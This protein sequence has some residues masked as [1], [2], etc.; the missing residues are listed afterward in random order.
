M[1]RSKNYVIQDLN[2]SS[3]RT[4]AGQS[5]GLACPG[6][7]VLAGLLEMTYACSATQSRKCKHIYMPASV[8]SWTAH[9]TF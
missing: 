7:D 4:G 1:Q 2:V 5:S 9:Q 3:K 6:Q 8:P